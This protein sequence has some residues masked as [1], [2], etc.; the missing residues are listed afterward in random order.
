[1]EYKGPMTVQEMAERIIETVAADRRPIGP[2]LCELVEACGA[3]AKGDRDLEYRK[4]LVLWSGVSETFADAFWTAYPRLRI[5]PLP[6]ELIGS[7]RRW[8]PLPL[9][10]TIREYKRPHWLAAAVLLRTE[11]EP[12]S[13]EERSPRRPDRSQRTPSTASTSQGLPRLTMLPPYNIAVMQTAL[14]VLAA[15]TE[16]QMPAQ[17]DLAQLREAAPE[18][19]SHR[20]DDLA[21]H[22]IET[23]LRNRKAA[24]EGE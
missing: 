2:S 22:V 17:S 6:E 16:H 20:M 3:G 1:M 18:F 15:I 19:A 7:G 23:A 12:N 8:L 21:C 10:S 9:A 14:R 4:N 13:E 11:E 5:Q 24:R